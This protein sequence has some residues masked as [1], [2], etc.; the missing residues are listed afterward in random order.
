MTSLSRRSLLMGAAGISATGL[1][2][3]C[4]GFSKSESTKGSVKGQL[5]FTTWA[6]DAEKSAFTKLVKAFEDAHSGTKVN[7]KIVPYGEMFTG[8]DNQLASNTAPDIFRVD[9]PT[10]GRYSSQEQLLDLSDYLDSKQTDDFIPALF[11]AVKYDDKPFGVPH[12]T[13]TTCIVYQPAMLEAAGITSTPDSL[14]SAWSW[15]EFNDVATKLKSSL[16]DGT[17][18]FAYD[19]QQYGA[20]R[21]LTWLFEAG[22]RILEEDLKTPAI[23]SAEGKK[24]LEYTLNFFDQQWVP[25]N[26]STKGASYPDSVFISQK[27][28]MAYVGDFLLPGLDDGIKSKFEWKATYQP[29]DVRASTD[30]GGN[31]LVATQQSKNP[32]LAAEF[33]K[34]MVDAPN[35]QAFC[36]EAIEL[37]TLQSLVD[38]KLN[39]ATRPDLMPYFVQQATTMTPDDVSQVAQPAA[40]EMNTVLM[41]ELE[42]CFISGQSVDDTLQKIADGVEK[43]FA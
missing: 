28:A 34:F 37:P 16:P 3:S 11:Q 41:N 30:L 22:G 42:Q 12:Q 20:Y 38:A 18:P 43:A 6:S 9:Y 7:L 26:T 4:G 24:A 1:L 25:K 31:A 5:T 32:E 15:E 36:E 33:L 35:M 29:K 40:G 17:Y 13:D 8:I 2:T 10:M 21:W 14:D 19:W 23:V 39:F 27:V